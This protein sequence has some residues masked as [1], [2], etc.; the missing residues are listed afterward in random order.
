MSP[1]EL[2]DQE[3]KHKIGDVVYSLRSVGKLGVPDALRVCGRWLEEC[4]GGFQKH[5]S[6][7]GAGCIHRLNET[8]VMSSE[9]V[10]DQ[11]GNDAD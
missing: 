5:Y 11:S 1:K 6:A 2:F 3:F 7:S 8:E 10:Q 9:Q 4:H